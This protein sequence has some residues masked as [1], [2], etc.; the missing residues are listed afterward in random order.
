ML[1]DDVLASMTQ[2]ATNA[3]DYQMI[4]FMVKLMGKGPK[5]GPIFIRTQHR[6]ATSKV[7]H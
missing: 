6:R 7:V 4:H 1:I 3:H 2:Y 5:Q